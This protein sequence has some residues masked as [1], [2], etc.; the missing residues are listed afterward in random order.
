M[1]FL[2]VTEVWS[3][4]SPSAGWPGDPPSPKSLFRLDRLWCPG[5]KRL[6]PA[7]V[8][9]MVGEE[10]GQAALAPPR[11]VHAFPEGHRLAG[12]V[13]RERHQENTDVVGLRLLHAAIRKA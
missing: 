7:L 2:L 1:S 3:S 9:G 4:P 10:L 13:V 8:A 11:L 6:D 5:L 12:V